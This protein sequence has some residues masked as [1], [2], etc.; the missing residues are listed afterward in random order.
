[1]PVE[2]GCKLFFRVLQSPHTLRAQS[3]A[4]TI[5]WCALLCFRCF[6]NELERDAVV[7]IAFAG[8]RRSVIEDVTVMPAAADAVVLGAGIKNLMIGARTEYARNA[9]EK[10]R[11]PGAAF[12]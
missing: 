8:R 1:M 3:H 10:T 12:E 9:R 2:P 7:A 11:P 4:R 5:L 6:G